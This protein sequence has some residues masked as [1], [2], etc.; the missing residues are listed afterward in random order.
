MAAMA[1][2][3]MVAMEPMSDNTIIMVITMAMVMVL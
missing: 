1:I 2:T 3:A